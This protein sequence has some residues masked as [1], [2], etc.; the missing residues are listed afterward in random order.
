MIVLRD[1]M[2]MRAALFTVRNELPA[3]WQ[4]SLCLLRRCFTLSFSIHLP[5]LWRA[6]LWF[7]FFTVTISPYLLPWS[8]RHTLVWPFLP[9]LYHNFSCCL[10]FFYICLVSC[11][12]SLWKSHPK[13]CSA[14]K[15]SMESLEVIDTVDLVRA[16][17]LMMSPTNQLHTQPLYDLGVVILI[18]HYCSHHFWCRL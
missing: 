2:T 6:R 10:T 5:P 8:L 16:Y 13:T 12:F 9:L 17:Q 4:L 14:Y 15:G 11:H 7:I 18:I 1:E 3:G